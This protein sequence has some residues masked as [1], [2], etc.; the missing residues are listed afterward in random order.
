MSPNIGFYTFDGGLYMSRKFPVPFDPLKKFPRPKDL[1]P[2]P[3]KKIVETLTMALL[4]GNYAQALPNT[5]RG[6]IVCFYV[7][8]RKC[9]YC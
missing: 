2:R 9:V 5:K 8:E 1:I 7:D 3:T 4:M 6:I